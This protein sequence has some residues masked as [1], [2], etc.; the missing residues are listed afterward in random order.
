MS[1]Q[2]LIV[3]V[4]VAVAFAYAAWALAPASL[5]RRF[6]CGRRACPRGQR[7]AGRARQ[8]RCELARVAAKTG[9]GCSD[10][11]ANVLTPAER[12]QRRAT[13]RARVPRRAELTAN[14]FRQDSCAGAR[15]MPLI[16]FLRA[17]L[18]F[19]TQPLLDRADFS[20]DPGERIGLIGRNGTGKSSLLGVILGR[21]AARRWRHAAARGLA[22]RRRRAGARVAAGARPCVKRPPR[23]SVSMRSRTSAHA[24]GP[25]RAWS[26]TCI[27]SAS[28]APLRRPTLSG[29]ERKRAALAAALA[30]DPQLL[31]LDEP[32]NHLDIEGIEQLETLLL[33]GPAAIV[34]T[35]DRSFL[36][37]VATRIVELDRGLLRSYPGNFA[38]L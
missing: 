6:A 3:V 35:H 15:L 2:T 22:H 36:D 33:D 1:A 9:G 13:H 25:R 30:L 8:A 4:V 38:R 21:I 24:G 18:A 5:R 10:C 20:L 12:K 26:N 7:S 31:L 14:C 19:G 27:A 29:G 34:V 37:R 16:T 32:T 23:A 17:E 28:T 11:A